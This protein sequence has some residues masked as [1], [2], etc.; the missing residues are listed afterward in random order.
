MPTVWKLEIQKTPGRSPI[1]GTFFVKADERFLMR[2]ILEAKGWFC[3]EQQCQLATL[4]VV[5]DV[6]NA[7]VPI[8]PLS[9]T[10]IRETLTYLASAASIRRV[11]QSH[12]RESRERYFALWDAREAIRHA[13][14]LRKA[15]TL[16]RLPL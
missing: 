6:P 8:A 1:Y 9:A 15:C 5:V 2:E 10:F 7:G 11:A 3:F 16:S 12:T 4:E 13:R 14:R